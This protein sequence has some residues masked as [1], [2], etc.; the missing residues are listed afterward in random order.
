LSTTG[1]TPVTTV[2][3]H[4]GTGPPRLVFPPHPAAPGGVDGRW[5]PRTQDLA[6]ELPALITAVAQRFGAVDR[7]SA[8]PE[9]WDHK[10]RSATIGGRVILLDW[11]GAGQRHLV[12]L[13]GPHSSRL[14]L[15][16]IPPGTAP[17]VALACL[18]MQIPV[19]PASERERLDRWEDDGGRTRTPPRG[20]ADAG[21]ERLAQ[22]LQLSGRPAHSPARRTRVR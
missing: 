8:D 20:P 4:G 22:V 1:T 7:I 5:W 2:G 21:P 9:A 14:E 15:L 13:F 18:M 17:V 11:F 12:G 3:P 16:V 6:V 10:P 19:A